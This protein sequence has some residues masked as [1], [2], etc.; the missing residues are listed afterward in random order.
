MKVKDLLGKMACWSD[1]D[2]IQVEEQLKV[3]DTL[4]WP[5][6]ATYKLGS[7]YDND[8]LNGFAVKD[9]IVR[10]FIERKKTT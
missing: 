10:I 4:N 7:I 6:C 5:D 9:N 3:I 8:R 2:T 1:I